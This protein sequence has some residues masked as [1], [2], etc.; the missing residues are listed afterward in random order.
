MLEEIKNIFNLKSKP[1]I[2][3][4]KITREIYQP[5]KK[6]ITTSKKILINKIK[7]NYNIIYTNDFYPINM[8][9]AWINSIKY[10]KNI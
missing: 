2:L 4:Y 8:N 7:K 1:K 5:D 9:K 10:S 3:E 6:W